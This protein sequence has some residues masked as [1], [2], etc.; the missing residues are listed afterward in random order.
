MKKRKRWPGVQTKGAAASEQ[1]G[2]FLADA[3]GTNLATG[4]P[5]AAIS[6]PTPWN[7]EQRDILRRR[8][9]ARSR[10]RATGTRNLTRLHG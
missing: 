10:V 5:A 8:L 7:G 9:S 4:D 1:L 3:S 2:G 6:S